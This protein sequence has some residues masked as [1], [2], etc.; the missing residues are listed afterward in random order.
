MAWGA[1]V[2]VGLALYNQHQ[3]KKA[4]KAGRFKPLPPRPMGWALRAGDM[5]YASIMS[6]EL[7]EAPEHFGEY[8]DSLLARNERFSQARDTMAKY[9][10]GSSFEGMFRATSGEPYRHSQWYEPKA[11]AAL[12]LSSDWDPFEFGSGDGGNGNGDGPGDGPSG[13][14][15]GGDA[16]IGVA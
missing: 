16:G 4:A 12:P 9:L 8:L 1:I 6:E 10:K 3:Q 5:D 11:Q 15:F 13:G 2:G 7:P 14:G